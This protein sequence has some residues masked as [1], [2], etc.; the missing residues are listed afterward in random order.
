MVFRRDAG[1]PCHARFVADQRHDM[2]RAGLFYGL[3]KSCERANVNH[4]R[5]RVVSYIGIGQAHSHRNRRWR[6][7]DAISRTIRSWISTPGE[8]F[9]P[10]QIT[11]LRGLGRPWLEIIAFKRGGEFRRA[12]KE[13]LGLSGCETG[14]AGR[15]EKGSLPVG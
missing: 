15:L 13:P 10:F 8:P 5:K 11:R 1:R 3:F 9:E 6:K 2:A 14:E 7:W 4:G 12:A